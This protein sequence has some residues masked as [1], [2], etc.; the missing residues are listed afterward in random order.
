MAVMAG[1]GVFIAVRDFIPATLRATRQCESELFFIDLLFTSKPRITLG[2]IYRPPGGDTKPLED[3]R[4]CIQDYC[5]NNQLPNQPRALKYVMYD[6][7]NV[8][9]KHYIPSCLPSSRIY[10]M[11]LLG[12]VNTM[13][14]KLK[15]HK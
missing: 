2:V 5:F 8:P 1:G 14:N 7:P 6:T 11:I 10:T 15:A 4:I 9:Y 12:N 13:E 3:L